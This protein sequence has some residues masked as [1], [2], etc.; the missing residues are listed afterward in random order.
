MMPFLRDAFIEEAGAGLIHR[1]AGVDPIFTPSGFAAFADDL[2]ARS[3]NPN[4]RDSLAR[5][6]RD[7]Q[8]KLGW[9]DR[10]IGA[11]RL[12]HEA[13]ASPL[14]YALGAAAALQTLDP[15]ADPAVLLPALWRQATPA[16]SE[17]AT[18]L[19]LVQEGVQQLKAWQAAE[20]PNLAIWW[21]EN[22]EPRT[23]ALHGLP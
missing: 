21:R 22:V 19:A 15:G 11:M 14:R 6:G 17:V 18:M 8:R 1:H 2:L 7:P 4:L 13:G 16:A 3:V 9:D 23:R 12:A 20:Y 5:V 10:L